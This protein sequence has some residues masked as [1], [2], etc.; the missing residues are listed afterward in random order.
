MCK[1]ESVSWAGESRGSERPPSLLTG[2]L[3]SITWSV[4][5]TPRALMHS[6]IRR[7]ILH[8][9]ASTVFRIQV[10]VHIQQKMLKIRK[11]SNYLAKLK[12][13]VCANHN[14]LSFTQEHETCLLSAAYE[15]YNCL[16]L[17]PKHEEEWWHVNMKLTQPWV[18]GHC[19]HTRWGH[20][21]PRQRACKQEGT[22]R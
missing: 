3:P 7:Q 2:T 11:Q 17:L 4:A 19:Q 21:S 18:S 10:I 22:A 5:G 13:T 6:T 9:R 16:F 15:H 20:S 1:S 8:L 14:F 12:I